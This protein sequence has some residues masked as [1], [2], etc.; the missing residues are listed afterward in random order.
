MSKSKEIKKPMVKLP[1]ESVIV[2]SNEYPEDDSL[3]ALY[4]RFAAKL[5]LLTG[6]KHFN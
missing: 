6:I 4:D 1:L 2:A 3:S 5:E